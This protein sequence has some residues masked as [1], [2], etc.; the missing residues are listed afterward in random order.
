MNQALPPAPEESFTIAS[1]TVVEIPDSEENLPPLPLQP[2]EPRAHPD[3]ASL[4]M[5]RTTL[6]AVAMILAPKALF[7]LG[8][9]GAF[10]VALLA[11]YQGTWFSLAILGLY[12]IITFVPMVLFPKG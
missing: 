5:I 3:M 2:Q 12:G 4:R 7:L 6:E 9:I 10:V 1:E 8:M 11:L